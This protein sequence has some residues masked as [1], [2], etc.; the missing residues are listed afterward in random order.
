MLQLKTRQETGNM[1]M[2]SARKHGTLRSYQEINARFEKQ[3]D[4]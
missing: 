4:L 1:Q 3:F 2:L